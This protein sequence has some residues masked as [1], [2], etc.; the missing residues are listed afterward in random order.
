M[1]ETARKLTQTFGATDREVAEFIGI[2]EATLYRW[3]H[4]H[5]DFCE[6]LN[7]GKEVS[8]GR[9]KQSLYR[10]AI[11][12]THDSEE[13]FSY[14]GQIT[15]VPTVKIYP[16]SEVAAIFWLKNRD[17]A[18]WR[19]RPDGEREAP[20]NQALLTIAQRLRA[21]SR[22]ID[23][24]TNGTAHEAMDDPAATSGAGPVLDEPA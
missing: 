12:Y 21:L 6:A 10:R 22:E 11:G 7:V 15:R 23:M 20:E 9:V 19:E 2:D 5:L 14:R 16:P 17:K 13:I 1:A 3:K 8:D 18:N 24:V 4:T